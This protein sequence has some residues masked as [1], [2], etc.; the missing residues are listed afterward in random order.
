M[1]GR[2]CLCSQNNLWLLEVCSV[3][4]FLEITFDIARAHKDSKNR[5][6]MPSFWQNKWTCYLTSNSFL[7]FQFIQPNI[8]KKWSICMWTTK[9]KKLLEMYFSESVKMKSVY[10]FQLKSF[11]VS[12]TVKSARPAVVCSK[13]HSRNKSQHW[14]YLVEM[15]YVALQE[16]RVATTKNRLFCWRTS[17][18]HNLLQLNLNPKRKKS[19]QCYSK[20]VAPIGWRYELN[21][22]LWFLLYIFHLHSSSMIFAA[23]NEGIQWFLD[24]GPDSVILTVE[25][26]VQEMAIGIQKNRPPAGNLL[27]SQRPKYL[28]KLLAQIANTPNKQRTAGMGEG[29][30][31]SVGSQKMDTS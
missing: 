5:W 9:Y 29:V 16:K 27:F 31:A 23:S 17:A 20:G 24:F 8:G 4:A 12:T 30:F 10:A 18:N 7:L 25:T 22:Q 11:L 21:I 15:G 28:N 14:L 1:R 2:S 13:V 26:F 3:V 6:N 19:L